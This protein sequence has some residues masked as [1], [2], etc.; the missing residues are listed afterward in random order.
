V[1]NASVARPESPVSTNAHVVAGWK[2]G[3]AA[4]AG[5]I[6]R[7]WCSSLRFS[8]PEETRRVMGDDGGA[9]LF[10]LWHNRLF[11][12]A[13]ISRRM[14]PTRPLHGLVSASKDGAWLSAFFE[15]V[16]LRVVRGSSSRGGREAVMA[17]VDVLRAGHDAGL[18]PDGPRGPVYVCKPGLITVARRA[19]ARVVLLGIHFSDAWRLRSWDRL[20]LPGPFSRVEVRAVTW[21]AARLDAADAREQ[22]E[23][24]LRAMNADAGEA[25]AGRV[26]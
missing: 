26:L 8:Y 3:L 18:T 11:V 15:N 25:D 22:V 10:V 14:R 7:V 2:R 6:V 17:L 24:A 5:A 21:D 12:A 20:A 13:E 4:V 9:S 16:G 19:G 1:S 23:A